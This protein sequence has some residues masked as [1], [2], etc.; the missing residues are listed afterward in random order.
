MCGFTVHLFNHHVDTDLLMS[1]IRNSMGISHRGPDNSKIVFLPSYNIL[2]VF[3]RLAINDVT[4]E[5]NQPFTKH[6]NGWDNYLV[7]NGEFYNHQEFDNENL[8]S[9]SDCEFLIDEIISTDMNPRLSSFNSEHS[10]VAIQTKDNIIRLFASSDRFGIRPMFMATVNYPSNE[11]LVFSSE[12]KVFSHR[13]NADVKR[14]DSGHFF[15]LEKNLST[16]VKTS[17]YV[18]YYNVRNSCIQQNS[19]IQQNSCIQQNIPFEELA[20]IVRE[21]LIEAVRIRLMSDRK[22]GFFLSGGLDS[23]CVCICANLL[24]NPGERIKTFSIGFPGSEDEI[25]ARRVSAELDTEHTHFILTKERYI[26]LIPE[27]VKCIGSFDTTTVRA[28]I[29]Q[30]ECS[31]LISKTDCIVLLSGDGSDELFFSYD[32]AKFCPSHSEFEERTFHLLENIHTSDGLRADR[33]VSNFGL[34]L[35]LP[36]LDINF[37]NL[38]LS[39]PVEYRFPKDGITKPLLRAAFKGFISDDI[40]YRPKVTFSDG[41]GSKEDQ[42]RTLLAYHFENYYTKEEFELYSGKFTHCKPTTNEELYYRMIFYDFYG[43][44]DTIAKTIPHFW[45]PVF[46]KSNDP[47]AWYTQ[48]LSN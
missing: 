27:V 16:S 12:L 46:K 47:S 29:G 19:F 20:V 11:C 15:V 37:V 45:K 42:S 35:R 43:N 3:H 25:Y 9:R 21:R 38:I 8:R 40:I 1:C 24:K 5:G 7:C 30:Y 13:S 39:S 36:F 44:N 17:R 34:E 10:F 18:R 33:C 31:R 14:F 48:E 32:D 23:T 28:S 22:K 26:R 4:V 6:S 2:I 41:V